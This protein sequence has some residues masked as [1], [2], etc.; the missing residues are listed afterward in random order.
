MAINIDYKARKITP[1]L[2]ID[3]VPEES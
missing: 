1:E 2:K 3:P